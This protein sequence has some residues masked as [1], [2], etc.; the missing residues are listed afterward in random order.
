[1]DTSINKSNEINEGEENVAPLAPLAPFSC[2]VCRKSKLKCDRTK[3]SC[4]R[5]SKQSYDCVYSLSRQPYQSK[6]RGQAK[7]LEAK[8]GRLERLLNSSQETGASNT[9]SSQSR[10][11]PFATADSTPASQEEDAFVRLGLFEESPPRQLIETLMNIYFSRIHQVTPLLHR[12]RFMAS[13]FLPDHMKPPMCLQ[14][15][16]MASAA[17]TS[18]AYRRLGMVFYKR[19]VKY[20]QQDDL[21]DISESS[22]TLGHVQARALI[23]C[24]EAEHS[25]FSKASITLCSAIRAAQM[26]NLH[27]VDFARSGGDQHIDWIGVEERRRTWWTIFCYDRFT[28]ATTGWPALIHDHNIKTRLPASDNAYENGQEE[29]TRFIGDQLLESEQHSTFAGAVLAAH[30]FHRTIEHTG[31]NNSQ[32]QEDQDFNGD[33]YWQRHKGIDNDLKFMLLM[34]PKNLCLPANYRT[35]NAI[36]VNV[37]LQTATICLHRAALWRMKSNLQGLPVYLIRLSQDRLLPAAEEILNIFRIIPDL[38]ATFTNP[39]ICFAAYMASLVFMASTSPTEP[40]REH[41][42]NLDFTL[43]ILATFGNTNLVAN[44]LANEIVKEMKQCG[45]T[46]PSMHKVNLQETP[47]D[48][49][50]LATQRLYSYPRSSFS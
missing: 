9:E 33:L 11:N 42:Q 13:L 7:E 28:C 21:G 35:H 44:A 36:F 43:K 12:Q 30:I 37:M 24:F 15:I 40:D 16:V 14:Y 4:S 8:L 49:P 32:Y 31:S 38:G 5:C 39:L 17:E 47:L 6:T 19:A 48:I 2:L 41:G 29:H 1:M 27:Q 22:I 18:D 45:I 10:Y 3:P 20:L 46:S 34:L 26:L 50:L 23:S 25:M